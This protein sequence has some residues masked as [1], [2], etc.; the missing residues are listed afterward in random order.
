MSE[1]VY[2]KYNG[3]NLDLINKQRFDYWRKQFEVVIQKSN[4]GISEQVGKVLAYNCA[5]EVVWDIPQAIPD[6]EQEDND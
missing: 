3:K 5:A 2:P 4:A 1:K 6:M